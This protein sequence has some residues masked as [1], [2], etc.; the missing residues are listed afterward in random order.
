MRIGF[1]EL[2]WAKKKTEGVMEKE[3]C[4]QDDQI[5][6]G[7]LN[8]PRNVVRPTAIQERMLRSTSS[9]LVML[10]GDIPGS[11]ECMIQTFTRSR[12]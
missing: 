5:K 12:G 7:V 1:L 9:S 8:I 10:F 2:Q 3:D 4:L 6:R 11:Q